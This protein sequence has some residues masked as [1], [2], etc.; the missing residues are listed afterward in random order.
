MQERGHARS[1]DGLAVGCLHSWVWAGGDLGPEDLDLTVYPHPISAEHQTLRLTGGT[2]P[3][4][5]QVEVHFRGVWNT[6]C[7][8]EWYTPEA[9]VLCR[10]L[11]CGTM[12]RKPEGL[13][14]S[15]S[16]RMYYSC[17]GEEP[18][19]SDCSWRYNNSNLCSQSK[20]ARVICSGTPLPTHLS[21]RPS[22]PDLD[23]EFHLSPQPKYWQLKDHSLDRLG[24]TN[25]GIRGTIAPAC[26]GRCC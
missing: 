10:A 18:T 22:H 8:T 15:L 7:D 23:Q 1:G 11:G 19:L 3:C 26:P 4:E 17:S 25:T 13:P 21:P 14:H 24:M 16:G 5:G 9:Q 2:D 20:A 6:V 12:A